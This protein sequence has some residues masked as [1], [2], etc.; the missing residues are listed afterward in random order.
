MIATLSD[1]NVVGSGNKFPWYN[2]LDRERFMNLTFGNTVVMGRLT[3]EPLNGPL[4]GTTLC[5]LTS[6]TVPTPDTVYTARTMEEAIAKA[7]NDVFIYADKRLYEEF[8][9][10]CDKLFLTRVYEH[11]KGDAIIDFNLEGWERT[12]TQNFGPADYSPGMSF[13]DYQRKS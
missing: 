8:V 7:N 13:L 12:D 1:N 6:R 3:W 5:I 4:P 10:Q 11:I 9:G 2:D